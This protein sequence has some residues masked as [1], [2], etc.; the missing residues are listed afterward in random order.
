MRKLFLS[1]LFAVWVVRYDAYVAQGNVPCA[2]T[3][4]ILV[5]QQPPRYQ[6]ALC[7]SFV[8]LPK[9]WPTKFKTEAEAKEA[10]APITAQGSI[11][12]ARAERIEEKK[13]EKKKD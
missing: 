7:S 12:N 8:L 13:E 6:Q 11:I 4:P 2:G 9:E 5:A 3:T 1:A 10:V